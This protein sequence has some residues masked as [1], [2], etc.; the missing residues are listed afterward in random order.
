MRNK[1]TNGAVAFL[2]PYWFE[3]ER[4]RY[5]EGVVPSHRLWGQIEL[6]R[7]GRSTMLC[8]PAPEAFHSLGNIGWRIWQA[9]WVW[10]HR[11]D[12]SAC[13]AVHE[14]SALGSL[15][16]AR[17]GLLN[18]P[19]ILI[20]FGLTHAR[21]VK[22]FKRLIWKWAL[23]AASCVVSLARVQMQS[24]QRLFEVPAA[25]QRLFMMPVDIDFIDKQNVKTE[26]SAAGLA[27]QIINAGA[28][29]LA[30]GTNDGKDFATLLEAWPLGERLVIITDSFN[31]RLIRSHRCFGQGIEVHESVPIPE[32]CALYRA[33]KLVV[34]PLKDSSHGSGH[35][36]LVE[37]MALGNLLIVSAS[38]NMADYVNDRVNAFSV[39][40][41]DVQGLRRTIEEVFCEPERFEAIRAEAALH[42]RSHFSS[43]RFGELL[44]VLISEVE[45]KNEDI[46]LTSGSL[47]MGPVAMTDGR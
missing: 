27:T 7:L 22:G 1:K 4:R 43:T 9:F 39:P 18:T 13:V 3:F 14:I 45:R 6:E 40:V 17:L 42:A 28:F 29:G 47:E 25:R 41:G 11:R 12:L 5:E 15:V 35:T 32:L 2:H 21:Q 37:N 30:V 23:G 44:S 19:I 8:P 20:N 34:I 31:A 38:Q 16:L 26:R 10:R 36:V 24:V 46:R 33:A